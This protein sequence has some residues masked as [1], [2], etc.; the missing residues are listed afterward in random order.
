M[1]KGKGLDNEVS[2]SGK[3][4]AAAAVIF[5]EDEEVSMY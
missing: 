2:G 4:V 5:S 1:A 3:G